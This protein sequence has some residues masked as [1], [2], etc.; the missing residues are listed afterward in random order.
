MRQI[1]RAFRILLLM[2]GTVVAAQDSKPILVPGSPGKAIQ[3]AT[4]A[5]A[6]DLTHGRPKGGAVENVHSEQNTVGSVEVLSDGRGV[7]FGPYLR[8]A[9]ARIRSHWYRLI[10][11]DARAKKGKL[12]IQFAVLPD[13]RVAALKLAESSGDVS[14]DRAAWQA[15]TASN[16]LPALPSAFSGP[17][18]ALRFRFYYNPDKGNLEGT[19]SGATGPFEHAVVVQSVADSHPPK[20]PKRARKEK[21]EGT[22]R[23]EAL[24]AADGKV[25]SVHAVEGSLVLGGA[26]CDAVQKWTFHPAQR[27]GKPVEDRVRINVEFRLDGEQV[28]AQIV[29]PD[30]PPS[31]TP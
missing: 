14:L 28:R 23:L 27:D 4:Q 17:N 9:M 30:A 18:L 21:V 25:E 5:A 29:W 7:N 1:E 22:V 12:A 8:D 26:A 15:I 20:Y 31:S 24:I 6:D 11:S 10:P 16:P 2:A 3:D 19:S 13:G